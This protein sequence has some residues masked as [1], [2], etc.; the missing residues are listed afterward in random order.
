MYVVCSQM[1]H[2]MKPKAKLLVTL[3]GVL[4]GASSYWPIPYEEL[5]YLAIKIWG[6]V[7]LGSLIASYFSTVLIKQKSA[8]TALL[9]T[10][11][12]I[13]SVII[14]ILYDIT[15]WDSTSHNLAPFE[16]LF[17][18]LQSLPMAYVGAYLAKVIQKKH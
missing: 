6:I 5:D 13:L 3:V 2:D 10:I 8:Q 7:G 18:G 9:I 11:G 14:R 16:I 4:V 15:F 1:H 12:V 17:S